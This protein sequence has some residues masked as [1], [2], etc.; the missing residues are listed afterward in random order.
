[1]ENGGYFETR[2]YLQFCFPTFFQL[3]DK[4]NN[5]CVAFLENLFIEINIYMV[6]RVTF[7]QGE[8]YKWMNVTVYSEPSTIRIADPVVM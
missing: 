8:C 6:K 1:M 3:L 4:C 5:I 7:T 2:T